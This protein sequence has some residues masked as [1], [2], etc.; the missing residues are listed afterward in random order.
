[1]SCSENPIIGPDIGIAS[2][3]AENTGTDLGFTTLTG[4]DLGGHH[5][6]KMKH[7]R[8]EGARKIFAL[9]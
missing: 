9:L 2:K 5:L 3:M 4:P 1:M 7:G 8:A 6:M